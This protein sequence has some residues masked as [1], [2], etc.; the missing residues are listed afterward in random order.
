MIKKIIYLTAIIAGVSCSQPAPQEPHKQQTKQEK[1]NPHGQSPKTEIERVEELVIREE[2]REAAKECE[3]ILLNDTNMRLSPE[4][5]STVADY[6]RLCLMKTGELNN[7]FYIYK[8]LIRE[9]FFP[10][11]MNPTV[12]RSLFQFECGIPLSSNEINI[13]LIEGHQKSLAFWALFKKNSIITE[14]ERYYKSVK[15][16]ENNSKQIYIDSNKLIQEWKLKTATTKHET[17][18]RITRDFLEQILRL[19][20]TYQNNKEILESHAAMML[21]YKQLEFLPEVVERYDKLGYTRLPD[22]IQ[23]AVIIFSQNPEISDYKG[24]EIEERIRNRYIGFWRAINNTY[25][26]METQKGV[27]EKFGNTYTYFFFI[28]EQNRP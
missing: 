27:K 2:Y 9:M 5:R 14:R 20:Y 6:L 7:N 1:Q 11:P 22:H 16:F 28:P 24:F 3:N 10:I 25:L 26:A 21:Y 18:V 15:D 19:F 17:R 8:A 12:A 23:E 4:I 13:M